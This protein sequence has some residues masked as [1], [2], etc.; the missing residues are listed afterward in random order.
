MKKRKNNSVHKINCAFTRLPNGMRW[1]PAWRVL[2]LAA[3]RILDL[4]ELELGKHRGKNNGR[5]CVTYQDFV[6]YGIGHNNI[7]PALRELETLGFIRITQRGRGGNAEFRSPSLYALTYLP[8]ATNG[9]QRFE[10]IKEAKAAVHTARTVG[11]KTPAKNIFRS[12]TRGAAPPP[13]TGGGN[14]HFSAPDPG[15][16][17]LDL[18]LPDSGSTSKISSQSSLGRAGGGLDEPV[19]MIRHAPDRTPAFANPNPAPC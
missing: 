3:R 5:I 13:D 6:R 18:S 2:S 16:E 7:G 19:P 15:S 14:G 1:S 9:W 10:T 4:L 8:P 12:P 11:K 17:A